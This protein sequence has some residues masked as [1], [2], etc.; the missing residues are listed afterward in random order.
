MA[1]LME[2]GLRL[3][4]SVESDDGSE[5]RRGLR[6]SQSR[7]VKVLHAP[8]GKYF[9]GQTQDISATG[10]RLELP[11]HASVRLG[12]MLSIHVGLSAD[13]S[14]LANRRQM[15]PAR[16]VWV[17]RSPSRQQFMTA[18]VEFAASIGAQLDAA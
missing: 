1:L 2:S 3:A 12:E 14:S 18:G 10:L 5:R 6:I 15:I 16:V 13:G 4:D 17:R 11:A 9:G 7:P 8:G